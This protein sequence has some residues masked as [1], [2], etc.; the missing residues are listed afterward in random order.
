[1]PAGERNGTRD[2]DLRIALGRVFA[3]WYFGA[4]WLS[5]VYG[6]AVTRYAQLARMPPFGF[7]LLAAFPFAGA[8]A[9]LVSSLLVERFGRHKTIFL[10]AGMSHRLLW[11]GIALVPWVTP[12]PWWWPAFLGLKLLTDLI[13][14]LNGPVWYTW[15]AWLVPRRLRGRFF[16][17]RTQAGTAVQLVTSVL[18]AYI[19]DHAMARGDDALLRTISV[20]F[21]VAGVFGAIDF[22][23][24][25]RVPAPPR[26]APLPDVTLWQ[27]VQQPLSD[28]NFLRFL[29]FTATLTFATGFLGPYLWLFAFE[30][31]HLSNT[32]ANG[33]FVLAPLVVGVCSQRLWGS[34]IDRFGR[35]PVMVI[36]NLLLIHGAIAWVLVTREHWVGGLL[37]V[38]IAV[39]AWHGLDLANFNM[40]L[41]LS[42]SRAGRRSSSAYAA[43]HSVAIALA[44]T[45]SGIFGG[46]IA[47]WTRDWHGSI[48]GLSLTYHTILFAISTVLRVFGLFWLAGL[49]DEKAFGTRDS[50]R[51]I[52]QDLYLSVQRGL[53]V[54]G[55][56]VRWLGQ[57]TYRTARAG[58][59]RRP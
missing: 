41:G 3:A 28:R 13:N 7:G 51:F 11:I 42:E 26:R 52:A 5:I 22:V 44:G 2:E 4:V 53:V 32:A 47:E 24:F 49:K 46:L 34:L 30:A 56:I 59:R 50:V 10:A 48:F 36:C 17:R 8:L 45:A 33:M 19:L 15:M 54:P 38:Q 31:L 57:M 37:L 25:I 20:L 27:M 16:G 21:A 23:F 58:T 29:G 39:V 43:V 9:Q 6:A 35:K 55:R 12:A 18:I 14:N 40:L 1:M